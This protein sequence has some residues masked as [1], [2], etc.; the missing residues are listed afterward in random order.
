[1]DTG[2]VRNRSIIRLCG[3]FRKGIYLRQWIFVSCN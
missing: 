1:M 2:T 3:L